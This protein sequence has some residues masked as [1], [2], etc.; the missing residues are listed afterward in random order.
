LPCDEELKIAV[1]QGAKARGQCG[2]VL[3][4][5]VRCG[6]PELVPFQLDG[7]NARSIVSGKI[8]VTETNSDR[9]KE[10]ERH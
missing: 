8:V 9:S 2:N 6:N 4:P 1:L 7:P 10:L 5:L 3:P